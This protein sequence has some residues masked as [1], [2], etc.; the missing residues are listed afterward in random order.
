VASG[1]PEIRKIEIINLDEGNPYLECDDMSDLPFGVL[2]ATGQLFRENIPIIC[3][4]IGLGR[5]CSK[6][7]AFLNGSWGMILDTIECRCQFRQ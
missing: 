1:A 4:G 6:C 3:G 2:G 5:N 7:Q